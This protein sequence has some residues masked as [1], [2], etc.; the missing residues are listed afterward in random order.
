MNTYRIINVLIFDRIKEAGKIQ[1]ILSRYGCIIKLR[2]GTHELSIAK[3]SRI[4]LIT[5]VL[6]GQKEMWDKLVEELSNLEGIEFKVVD[7]QH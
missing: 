6:G 1:E 7:F 4:S 3:N 5:L 2:L